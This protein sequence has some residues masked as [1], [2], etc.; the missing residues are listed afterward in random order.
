MFWVV[1]ET[2]IRHLKCWECHPSED[3][4]W[5]PEAGFSGSTKHHF[6]DTEKA[7]LDKSI[8]NLVGDQLETET[9]LIKLRKRRSKL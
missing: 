3:M 2:G 7:A 1:E 6:F 8:Q 9:L 5:C 4:W